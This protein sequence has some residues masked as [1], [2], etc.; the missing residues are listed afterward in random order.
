MKLGP[1]R[2]DSA[3]APLYKHDDPAGS[4]D[5]VFTSHKAQVG[6]DQSRSGPEGY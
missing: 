1:H 4:L 2:D 5:D 3:R 6:P